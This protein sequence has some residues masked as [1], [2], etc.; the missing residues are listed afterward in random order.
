M[1]LRV[2]AFMFAARDDRIIR[3]I[4]VLEYWWNRVILF[5]HGGALLKSVDSSA[6][7]QEASSLEADSASASTLTRLNS[8]YQMAG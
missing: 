7:S 2:R 5:A 3:P 4:I 8:L 1:L 6:P